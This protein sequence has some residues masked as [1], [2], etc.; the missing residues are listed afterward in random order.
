MEIGTG[1]VSF[2]AIGT[3]KGQITANTDLKSGLTA[4]ERTEFSV[5]H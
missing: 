5:L 3:E 4:A 2:L 1:L